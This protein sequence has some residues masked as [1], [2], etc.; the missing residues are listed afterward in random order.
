VEGRVTKKRLEELIEEATTDAYGES[1]QAA[2]FYTMMENDLHLPF[3]THILSVEVT[4]ES[5][6]MTD[7]DNIVANRRRVHPIRKAS[8][9]FDYRT[10]LALA[11]ARRVGVDRGIPPL[12]KRVRMNRV[13]DHNFA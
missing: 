8:E 12:A 13:A 9:N 1:E 7:D 3:T 5:I 2:G 6:D 10:A 4:G 11:A